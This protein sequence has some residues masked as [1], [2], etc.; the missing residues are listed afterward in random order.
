MGLT[1]DPPIESKVIVT[2]AG[3][4]FVEEL[5]LDEVVEVVPVDA[6]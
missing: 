1:E 3:A 4:L 2:V 5:V 6:L